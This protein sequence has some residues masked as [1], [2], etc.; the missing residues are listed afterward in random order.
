MHPP[1]RK[2][3]FMSVEEALEFLHSLSQLMLQLPFDIAICDL[4]K[5]EADAEKLAKQAYA[6]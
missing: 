2:L 3:C 5:G 6:D 4:K 1:F